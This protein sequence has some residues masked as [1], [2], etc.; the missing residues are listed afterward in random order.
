MP[1]TPPP[2]GEAP[3]TV[4]RRDL[5]V[6]LGASLVLTAPGLRIAGAAGAPTP[7]VDA[8]TLAPVWYNAYGLIVNPRSA[9]VPAKAPIVENLDVEP[10][11]AVLIVH[12]SETSNTY[13]TQDVPKLL[14]SFRSYGLLRR[15]RRG[16]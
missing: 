3:T 5:L 10:S 9:W 6:S 4:S 16:E 11:V 8:A 13:A 12:H 15:R 7:P 2:C 14:R 1:T